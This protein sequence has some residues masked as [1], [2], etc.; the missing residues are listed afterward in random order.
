M[1]IIFTADSNFISKLIRLMTKVSWIK[2]GRTSHT[3]LRYGKEESNWMVESNSR[4]FVPNWWPY[5]IKKSIIFAKFEV[6]GIE[7]EVLE[8]IVDE[9]INK[10]IN[11][12]YDY[13]S[14]LGFVFMIIMYKLTGKRKKNPLACPKHFICSEIVYRIFR[15]VK[16]QTGINYFE[17]KDVEA[18]FP[19][20]LLIEC[21][22]KPELFKK[23]EA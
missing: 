3:A 4:G 13:G 23:I 21:E 20:E 10:S 19:E 17:E 15:E 8:K 14:I 18:I 1:Q 16:R 22:N 12:N 5:F 11:V 7:E 6:L 2:S 9:Q